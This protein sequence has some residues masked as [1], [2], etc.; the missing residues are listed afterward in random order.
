[1]DLIGIS[2]SGLCAIHCVGLPLLMALL[3]AFTNFLASVWFHGFAMFLV[4]AAAVP[5]FWRRYRESG[6]LLP[7]VCGFFG[8][9]FLV[10]GLFFHSE[11]HFH[12]GDHDHHHATILT[13]E[14]ILTMV[15]SGFFILG[16]LISLFGRGR[17]SNHIC[18]HELLPERSLAD[19]PPSKLQSGH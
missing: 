10:L 8:L 14:S 15:G 18:A 6:L 12:F 17:V 3:P 19:Q 11:D 4:L 2:V 13:I 1:M 9:C 7:F 5:I 16:H